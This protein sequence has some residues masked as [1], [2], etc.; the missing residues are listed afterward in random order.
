M[1]NDDE[2]YTSDPPL[3]LTEEQMRQKAVRD[4]YNSA[5]DKLISNRRTLRQLRQLLLDILTEPSRYESGIFGSLSTTY[6]Q[7]MD[8]DALYVKEFVYAFLALDE[9]V[10]LT[11]EEKQAKLMKMID[12]M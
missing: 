10:V 3:P 1:T 8:S 6:Q 4:A 11:F 5:I 7:A 12:E 2:L 9:H